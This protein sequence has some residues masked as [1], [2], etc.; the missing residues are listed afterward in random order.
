MQTCRI[1]PA[2]LREMQDPDE[3]VRLHPDGRNSASVLREIESAA[4]DDWR[5]ILE[6]LESIVPRTVGVQPKEARQ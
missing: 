3:G 5:T 6:L 2:A 4:P 1:E